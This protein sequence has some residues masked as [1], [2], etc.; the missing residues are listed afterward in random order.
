MIRAVLSA[1][2]FALVAIVGCGLMY[3]LAATGLGRVLFPDQATGSIVR[4]DGHPVGSRLVAQ[5][6]SSD[7]YLYP[8]P[9]ICGYDP[10]AAAGSN[11]A[12]SNPDLRARIARAGREVARREGIDPDAVPPELVAAS[13]SC[14]D[15][16]LSPE[17]ALLQ[18]G[19]VAR[20]RGIPEAEVE[21]AIANHTLGTGALSLGP[22]RVNVLA[23]NLALD[24]I[25][26]SDA[27]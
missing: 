7:T 9:S 4:V 15:P 26:P 16:D 5:P 24:R 22:P 23:T 18:V 20:A 11:Q 10:R 1:L 2:R 8:R 17:A 13:G 19:R 3:P 25:T 14:I 12:T 6:A 27:R 21:A